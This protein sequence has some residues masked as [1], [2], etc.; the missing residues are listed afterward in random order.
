MSF[1][2][3]CFDMVTSSSGSLSRK[4]P[5]TSKNILH[6]LRAP[7]CKIEC[8]C[9]SIQWK[10]RIMNTDKKTTVTIDSTILLD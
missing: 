6:K 10:A 1:L 3:V 5:R 4:P 7:N 8:V 9:A 2:F